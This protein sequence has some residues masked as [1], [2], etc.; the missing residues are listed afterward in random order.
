M[1]KELNIIGSH[2]DKRFTKKEYLELIKKID[3]LPI[4]KGDYRPYSHQYQLDNGLNI[5]ID[6]EEYMD[7]I[8][9]RI[10]WVGDKIED[11]VNLI[12]KLNNLDLC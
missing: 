8:V 11:Y 4:A 9:I 5:T 7:N 10:I 3:K 12:K 2:R 1:E 6:T